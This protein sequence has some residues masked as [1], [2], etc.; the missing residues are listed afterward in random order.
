MSVA[1]NKNP[2]QLLADASDAQPVFEPSKQTV[3]YKHIK[4]NNKH[5][6]NDQN[7]GDGHPGLPSSYVLLFILKCSFYTLDSHKDVFL[8]QGV[9]QSLYF[10]LWFKSCMQIFDKYSQQTKTSCKQ[11]R[12][13]DKQLAR[14]I[15]FQI[16]HF[17]KEFNTKTRPVEDSEKHIKNVERKINQLLFTNIPVA[18]TLVRGEVYDTT[19]VIMSFLHGL[20]DPKP[21]AKRED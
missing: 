11:S 10:H 13:R 21:Q 12:T 20:L 5:E 19:R 6:E 2:L 16:S 17:V 4:E 15:I 1:Q 18:H 8:Y 3:L 9:K 14:D 7:I